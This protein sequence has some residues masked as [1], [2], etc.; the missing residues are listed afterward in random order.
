M[1]LTNGN[2]IIY[3]LQKKKK[4][5]KTALFPYF[6]ISLTVSFF[7]QLTKTNILVFF[8]IGV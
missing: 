6:S 2:G 8:L 7:Y 1:F 4:K 3:H 5:P